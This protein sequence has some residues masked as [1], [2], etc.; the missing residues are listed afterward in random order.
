MKRL[1]PPRPPDFGVLAGADFGV[2]GSRA[3]EAALAAAAARL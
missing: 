2:G 1:L 3:M